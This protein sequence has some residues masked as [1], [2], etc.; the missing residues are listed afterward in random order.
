MQLVRV[1]QSLLGRLDLMIAPAISSSVRPA[2][3]EAADAGTREDR[4][5]HP[6]C[7]L[8]EQTSRRPHVAEASKSLE[9]N[10]KVWSR[11]ADSNR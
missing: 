9:I 3:N 10:E 11:R 8:R 4:D 2:S 7:T 6:M 5:L 1:E